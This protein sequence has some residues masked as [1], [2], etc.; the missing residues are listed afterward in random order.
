MQDNIIFIMAP[1]CTDVSEI[2]P[3]I[4]M[5]TENLFVP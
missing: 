5:F 1:L 2:L 3:A 4:K